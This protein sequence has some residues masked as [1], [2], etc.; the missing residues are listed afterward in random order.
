MATGYEDIDEVINQSN[1]LLD[2]SAQEQ[3]KIID[4]GIQK[5][6]NEANKQK[7][8]LDE[9][10]TKQ[11]KQLYTDMRKNINPYVSNAE[12]L[13]S[14]WLNKSGYAETSQVDIYNQYQKNVTTLAVETRKAKSEVDFGLQQA[15]IDADIQKAESVAN[16]FLQK[17]QLLM[18]EYEMKENRDNLEYQKQRDA[19]A[20]ARYEREFE[21]SLSNS[22]KAKGSTSGINN[23]VLEAEPSNMGTGAN[24]YFEQFADMIDNGTPH[25]DVIAKIKKLNVS[26]EIKAQIEAEINNYYKSQK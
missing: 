11:G 7:L 16:N 19:I 12:N 24:I 2:K 18:Q 10:A 26:D 25:L 17:M 13:A 22:K 21:L 3:N 14:Q 4:L 9:E 1:A 15:R 8:E 23:T 5:A 20:D 6:T